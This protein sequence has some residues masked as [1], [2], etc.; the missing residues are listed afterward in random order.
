MYIRTPTAKP[1]YTYIH[2]ARGELLV[3]FPNENVLCMFDQHGKFVHH[4][5]SAGMATFK[6][7]TGLALS[8]EGHIIVC[9]TGHHRVL[10]CLACGMDLEVVRVIGAEVSL[11]V[12]ACVFGM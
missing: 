9:D 11:C 5:L 2:S 6:V 3:S 7:P 10:V 8:S 12:C 4:Y 1:I